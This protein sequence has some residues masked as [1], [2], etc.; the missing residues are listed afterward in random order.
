M[1]NLKL[2]DGQIEDLEFDLLPILEEKFQIKL[3]YN[4]LSEIKDFDELCSLIT[5]KLNHQNDS[6]CTTQMAFY[7]LRKTLVNIGLNEAMI[8]PDTKLEDI[9]PKKYRRY[10]VRKI[11]TEL[12]IVMEELSPNSI[13]FNVLLALLVNFILGTIFHSFIIGLI[14]IIISTLS[15]IIAF[16]YWKVVKYKT[17][18]EMINGT[19]CENYFEYRGNQS[20]VN[21]QEF[22]GVLM[23]WF[24]REL[25]VSKEE[26]SLVSFK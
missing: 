11:E 22:K 1:D 14:G 17:I 5:S 15:F 2:D 26:L 20:S 10:L 3:E 19:A 24:S 9:L 12:G 16:R 4:D 21:R 8:K 25:A 23:N 18:R 13:A 6:L 7:K